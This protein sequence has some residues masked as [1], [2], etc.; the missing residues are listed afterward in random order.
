MIVGVGITHFVNQADTL[1]LI[2]F[3]AERTASSQNIAIL[4]LRFHDIK[5]L[6]PRGVNNS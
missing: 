1:I 2:Y 6:A 3:F 5:T 4:I